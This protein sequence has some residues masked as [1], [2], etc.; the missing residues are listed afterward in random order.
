MVEIP[1]AFWEKQY[2]KRIIIGLLVSLFFLYLVF[3]QIDFAALTRAFGEVNY[4]IVF[5]AV[6]FHFVGFHLR[7]LRWKYLLLSLKRIRVREL[8]PYLAIGYM[9]N[10]VLF[11]RLG[12]VVRAH[13]VGRAYDLSRSSMLAVILAERLFDGISLVLFF[14]FLVLIL[15]LQESLRSPLILASI[16]FGSV[17]VGVFLLPFIEKTFLVQGFFKLFERNSKLKRLLVSL[18][19]FLEGLKTLKSF[20]AVMLVLFSSV[21]IWMVEAG[22]F[23]IIAQSFPLDLTLAQCALIAL[24]VGLSTLIPSGPGY[25]GTYEFF[26]VSVATSFGVERNMAVSYAFITHFA[27]WLPIT[28]VGFYYAWK[29]NVSL[30]SLSKEKRGEKKE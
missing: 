5:L 7:A 24:V 14:G 23:W 26:F 3:R 19:A 13:V 21:I 30:T 16:L 11:L 17:A 15:P 27:Q 9:A 10:N 1:S 20:R 28:L 22:M 29:M 25:V 18:L 12:E 6:C 2:M 8:F 4:F